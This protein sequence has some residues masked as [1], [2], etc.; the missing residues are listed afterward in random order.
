M[1]LTFERSFASHPEAEFWS[2]KNDKKPEEVHMKSQKKA[3]FN[4]N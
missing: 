4:C 1:K 3:W 2:L